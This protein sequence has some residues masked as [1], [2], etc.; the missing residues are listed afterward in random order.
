MGHP[1]TSG[2]PHTEQAAVRFADV[3]CGFGG[4]LVKLA[5]LYP[6]ALMLGMELRDKVMTEFTFI[7]CT[8]WDDSEH[9]LVL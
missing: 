8:L 3:G 2:G 6:D 9:T 7:C 5:P 1:G 4:L